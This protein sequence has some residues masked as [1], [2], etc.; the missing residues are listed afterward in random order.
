MDQ[1]TF[2][3][4][5]VLLVD[6][7]EDDYFIIKKI[8][9][10]INDSPF[11]LDWTPSFD[12]AAS[13]IDARKHDIYLI[14]YRLGEHTG[15]DLLRLALP[16]DRPEPFILLTGASDHNIERRS[17]KLA[18]ADYL[19]KGSFDAQLLSRTLHYALQRK[20]MEE[21]RLSHL[22][23]LNRSK[24]EFIS[25]AS[26]QLRTPATGVKQYIGML[27]E[28]FLGEVPSEQRKMLV[29]AYESNERQLQIVSDL[30]KV[31]RVDAGK[32]M[33]KKSEVMIGDLIADIIR[34]QNATF[35][36]RHQSI[37]YQLLNPDI[38]VQVDR[39]SIRMVLENLIDNAGKYS[40]EGKSISVEVARANKE[41]RISIIDHGVGINLEDQDR[42]FKKFSRI[43]N[44]LSTKVGG[45]GLGL[46]W[47]KKIIDLHDGE[48]TYTP[49]QGGGATFVVLIPE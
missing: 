35:A 27:L 33:L 8:F 25:I 3:N 18:A 19:V 7:D 22:V 36:S 12:E 48:I 9:G 34:E 44:S 17:M 43:N 26:H 16:Q 20:Q 6:D 38:A 41:I 13:L 31:A 2:K 11:H 47:A 37:K 5:R 15:L 21:Q 30:L 28:G 24:D 42:L 32:V 4:V 14:D 1:E 10:Q 23:E 40:E 39:D 46:Y 49:T 45:T 29:K